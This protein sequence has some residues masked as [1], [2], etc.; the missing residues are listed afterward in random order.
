MLEPVANCVKQNKHMG[1]L[2][3]KRMCSYVLFIILE[4]KN[5]CVIEMNAEFSFSS[6][7]Q[8]FLFYL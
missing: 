7:N 2:S 6:V 4:K 3:I 8:T 5:V 1:L